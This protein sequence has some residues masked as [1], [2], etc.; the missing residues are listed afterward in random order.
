[1][2]TVTAPVNASEALEIVRAGMGF[3]AAADATAMSAAVQ[4]QCL[5]ALEEVDSVET[6]ARA[7]VLRAFSAGQGDCGDGEYSAKTWLIHKTRTSRGAAAHMKW[8][9]RAAAHPVVAAALGEAVVSQSWAQVIC[10]QTGRLPAESRG[11]ADA[12]LLAAVAGGAVLEDLVA[13]GQRMYEMS[14]SATPT[15]TAAT[16]MPAVATAAPAA[17]KAA[18]PLTTVSAPVRAAA[19]VTAT[20]AEPVA[21][22]SGSVPATVTVMRTSCLMTGRCGCPRRS[23]VPGCWPVT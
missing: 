1:V 18:V 22:V 8:A 7:S 11:E 17:V 4:A 20:A 3:L 2:S 21:A 16:A 13:R 23:A 12:I 10:Q 15:A 19:S 6:V 9:R 5:Q 14:C